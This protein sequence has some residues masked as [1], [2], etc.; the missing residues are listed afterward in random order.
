[1]GCCAT[2]VSYTHLT[3]QRVRL[4]NVYLST[5]QQEKKN[6]KLKKVE[7][8]PFSNKVN[9]RTDVYSDVLTL[10]EWHTE[11]GLMWPT[12]I[13]GHKKNETLCTLGF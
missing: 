12:N 7:S 5:S 1:M 6:H 10:N 3:S 13:V 9:K 4:R 8:G 2:P 11:C